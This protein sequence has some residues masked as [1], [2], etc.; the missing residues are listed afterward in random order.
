MT[1]VYIIIGLIL[2]LLLLAGFVS[3]EL[4]YEKSILIK[5]PIKKVW[6]Y[7]NSLTALDKWSPWN[8]KDQNMKK[9]LIGIDG[10]VG[11][12]QFWVSN[13]KNVGE[14]SQKIS[15]IVEPTLFE[16]K[17]N[18]IKPFKS[19]ADGYVK[20][21]DRGEETEAAWGF[22]SKMPY[23][24]NLVKLFMNFEKSMDAEFS[25]GLNKLKELCEK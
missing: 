20:L 21:L 2:L 24:M 16:T 4:N 6:K 8:D 13:V 9:T 7:T 1:I 19:F 18:F 5:S 10:T 3:R 25:K 11:A 14:G 12:E 22:K 23:P 17:L 15:N